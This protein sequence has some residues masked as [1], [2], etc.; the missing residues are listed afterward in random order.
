MTSSVICD[1]VD[2]MAVFPYIRFGNPKRV[3]RPFVWQGVI[4]LES[5]LG[6]ESQGVSCF[7]VMAEGLN[8]FGAGIC[9]KCIRILKDLDSEIRKDYVLARTKCEGQADTNLN[10]WKAAYHGDRMQKGD[11]LRE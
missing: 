11:E 8:V 1:T 10:R 3:G 5:E 7:H 2:G 9:H 6:K 4:M